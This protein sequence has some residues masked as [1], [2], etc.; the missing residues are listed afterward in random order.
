MGVAVL[1]GA[2]DQKIDKQNLRSL[3]ICLRTVGEG[4]GHG[5]RHIEIEVIPGKHTLKKL[6]C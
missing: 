4:V 6:V 5:F 3:E 2:A 1:K